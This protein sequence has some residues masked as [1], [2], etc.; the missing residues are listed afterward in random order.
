NIPNVDVI[1]AKNL[2]TYEV[3]RA[4]KLLVL[5]SSIKKIEE[6]CS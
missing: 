2:N 3:L 6:I 4:N 5:E 1:N